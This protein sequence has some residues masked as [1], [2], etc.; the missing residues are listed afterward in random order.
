MANTTYISP[1]IVAPNLLIKRASAYDA[2]SVLVAHLRE[3]TGGYTMDIVSI[4]FNVSNANRITITL[5]NPLP[6]QAQVDRYQLTQ[7]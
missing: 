6:D 3:R 2:L 7:V 5:T 1:L 4:D